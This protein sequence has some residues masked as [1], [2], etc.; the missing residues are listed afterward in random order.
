ME[1][2]FSYLKIAG[3]PVVW[4]LH[5]C[6]SFTGHC[7]YYDFAACTKWQTGCENCVQHAKTYPYAI[8]KDNSKNSYAR[9]RKAFCG[10]PNLTIVTPSNWLKEQVKYSFLREYPVKVIPNGIDLSVFHKKDSKEEPKVGKKKVLG[11]ANVW[12]FR[13]G[14]Q[15]FP[16]L[17]I[18]LGT[19]YEVTVIG[20]S[21]KQQKEL[22]KKKIPQS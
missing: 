5:D 3:I 17:A 6:W 8:F 11:V 13:K 12:E 14:L 21:K 2:L 4:T 1:L 22:E 20:V 18:S 7:A 9:K 10:I 15:T 16:K 19:E